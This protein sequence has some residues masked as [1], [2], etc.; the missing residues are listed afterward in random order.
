[1]RLNGNKKLRKIETLTLR[2]LH[3]SH[4][5]AIFCLFVGLSIPAFL[6]KVLLGGSREVAS[7][8]IADATRNANPHT[9]LETDE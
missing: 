4:A 8:G 6:G 3:G 9:F 7:S 2:D 1:M 5:I